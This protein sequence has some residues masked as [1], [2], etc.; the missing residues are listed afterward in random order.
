MPNGLTNFALRNYINSI[1]GGQSQQTDDVFNT[2]TN[3]GTRDLTP[4]GLDFGN[5]QIIV[6]YMKDIIA[7]N[8]NPITQTATANIN[9]SFDKRA[10]EINQSVV[11]RGLSRSGVGSLIQSELEGQRAGAIGGTNADILQNAINTLLATTSDENRLR[12]SERS[13]DLGFISN[14]I[15]G[16]GNADIRN[17]QEQQ[18]EFN[19]F[20]DLLPGLIQ[21]GSQIGAAEILASDKRF[22]NNIKQVGLSDSAIPIVEFS[23]KGNPKKFRGAIAQDVELIDPDAVL[24]DVNGMKYVNYDLIDIDFQEV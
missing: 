24:E 17:F 5:N 11:G 22:K 23:Y 20:R 19:F 2:L 4:S 15:S 7:G 14:L 6:D 3:G 10:D 21:G 8:P 18:S 16:K 12:L 1:Y 13:Q 9:K